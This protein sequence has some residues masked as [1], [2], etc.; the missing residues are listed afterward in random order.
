MINLYILNIDQY[1]IL[2]NFLVNNFIEL[3]EYLSLSRRIH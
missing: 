1:D 2:N 3:L